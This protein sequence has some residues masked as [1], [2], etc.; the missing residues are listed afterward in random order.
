MT[1]ASKSGSSAGE[2]E[3]P[4]GSVYYARRGDRIKI[5]YS[6]DV[7]R[8]LLYRD[9]RPAELR[10]AEPGT[11]ALERRRHRQFSA[12]RIE[13]EWF[14]A[15][16]ALVTYV[17]AVALTAR[18]R[19]RTRVPDR[20]PLVTTPEAARALGLSARTLQRYVTRGLIVPHLLLP[21]G[22]YRWDVDRLRAEI[23][24]LGRVP[25]E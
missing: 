1:F 25:D 24:A 18:A 2:T 20:P 23:N 11:F 21:S 4:T 17:S 5:G 13:G 19:R 16:P 10:A 22:R 8:R 9:V 6:G 15:S 7:R 12:D 3:R 14:R